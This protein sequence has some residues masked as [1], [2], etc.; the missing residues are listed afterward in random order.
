MFA[1]SVNGLFAPGR[2]RGCFALEPLEPRLLLSAIGAPGP[3]NGWS[4]AAAVSVSASS[5]HAVRPGVRAID[6]SGLDAAGELHD[7]SHEHMWLSG[8]LGASSAA[9]N[10]G[11]VAGSHWIR[12]DFDRGYHLTEAWIWNYN[13]LNWP[14]FGMKDVTIQYSATGGPGPAEWSTA[15][16]GRIPF[17]SGAGVNPDQ[18]DLVVD[19]GGAEARHVVITADASGGERNWSIGRPLVHE[20]VGLSEVRFFHDDDFTG[21]AWREAAFASTLANAAMEAQFHG[22]ILTRLTDVRTGRVLLN[23]APAMMD[24]VLPLFGAVDVDLDRATLNLTSTP[25]ARSYALTFPDGTTWTLDWSLAGA[26]LVLSTRAATPTPVTQFNLA[27]PGADLAGH[28]LVMV[29]QNG[30]GHTFTAPWTGTFGD[31]NRRQMPQTLVQPLVGLFAGDD[32]GWV[33]E[34]RDTALGPSVIRSWGAGQTA[35]VML[36]RLFPVATRDPSLYDVHLRTYVDQWQDAVDPYVTWMVDEVGFEPLEVRQPSWLAEIRSQAYVTIG[37]YAGLG[38][39]ARR[40]DPARTFLGRQAEYRAFPFDVGY[41]DYSV[42]PA[43][44]AWLATARGLGFHVGVH[45]NIA[46]IDRNDTALIEQF[47]PGLR[48]VGTDG[49]GQP[50]W[51]GTGTHV[52]VSAAHAPWRAFLIDAIADVVAAGADVIYLDQ[53]TAPIGRYLVDGVNGI[54][55]VVQLERELLEAYPHVVIQTEQF[56][57]MASRHAGLAL[58]TLSVG[59]P[60]S[61]YVFERFVKVVPEGIWYQPTDTALLDELADWGHFVPGASTEPGWL[62]IAGAFQQYDLA[63][64]SRLPRGPGQGSGFSGPGGVTAFFERTA[65]TRRFAVYEPGVP[66]AA[67]GERHTNI[68]RWSGPGAIADWLIHD[69]GTM[70]G[71]DPQRTYRFDTSVTLDPAR[72]HLTAVPD[73]YLPHFDADRRIVAQETGFDDTNFRLF[74]TGSGQVTMHVP[75]AYDVYLDDVQVAVDRATDTAVVT[76]AAPAGRPAV[77][78]AFARSAQPLDGRWSDHAWTRPQHKIAYVSQ[79]DSLFQPDG[80]FNHIG[81][82]GFII[83]WLPE[84]E[85]VHVLGGWQL[86]DTF[87]ATGGDGVLRVNGTE[88]LRLDPGDAPGPVDT[89]PMPFDVDLTAWSGRFVM[90]EF[91]VDG[92]VHGPEAADWIAPEFVVTAPVPDTFV[93]IGDPRSANGWRTTDAVRV[94]AWSSQKVTRPWLR[95]IDGSGLDGP[96]GSEHDNAFAHMGLTDVLAFGSPARGGTVP[97]SHWVEYDLGAAYL[98]EQMWIWNYNELNW[99]AFGMKDVTIEYSVTGSTNATDWTTAFDGRIPRA[100]ANGA[101]AGRADRVVLFGGARARYVVITTDAGP[102]M[103]HFGDGSVVDVGLSEVRFYARPP[104]QPPTQVGPLSAANVGPHAATVSWGPATDPED[105]ALIYDVQVRADDL[106]EPWSASIATSATTT[107]LAGLRDG[108][109]YRVRVR[110]RDAEGAGA[111]RVAPGLFTTVAVPPRVEAVFVGAS[112][113]SA[114]FLESVDPGARRGYPIPAGDPDQLAPLPWPGLDRV[115]IV[116]S[117]YVQLTPADIVLHGVTT[118]V[119]GVTAFDYDTATFAATW[120]FASPVVADRLAIVLE[121][122]IVDGQHL[123]LDG[124]WTDTV[125][126]VSGNGVAGGAFRFRL[127]VL[128]G[129]LNR[130][131]ATTVLD[132]GPLRDALSAPSPA[133]DLDGDGALTAAD[134]MA[135]RAH[136]GNRLPDGDPP[137]AAAAPISLLAIASQADGR[138]AAVR[139]PSSRHAPW[140]RGPVAASARW[141]ARFMNHPG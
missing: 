1:P 126:L 55:G 52:Y 49:H 82:E 71:L 37:D 57:P 69:G 85:R 66:P 65:T 41:P 33:I 3:A 15:F 84:A 56:N 141:A 128:V 131:G 99:A 28:D 75:D 135:L 39:L 102:H 134:G 12:F 87:V 124:E 51:D 116:F 31:P 108:T 132:V 97:G 119:H 14:W 83:G 93:A 20:E 74:Q 106:S 109:A 104:N 118:G 95:T 63:P 111:W 78:R 77:I 73:D 21:P 25:N 112:T 35:E 100:G 30:T 94:R 47:R 48:Q 6:G 43:A 2:G 67:Y 79:Q 13:E 19:F 27:F 44:A 98:L 101:G 46:G 96:T 86:R 107:A 60:L 127:N 7:N 26:D 110:A 136:L 123:A 32:G 81:G 36:S 76:L 16:D 103:N 11:T 5:A 9:P 70:Y 29:D 105:D 129:D 24:P 23:A 125:S 10:P 92:P 18:V 138:A 22:G 34:G 139:R 91:A 53:S 117:E 8:L 88:V 54:Q 4:T 113:W 114:A 89:G 68:R 137:G 115:T 42:T 50:I 45:V 38:D 121:D 90:F 58:T 80:F 59:H 64:D 72:F 130:D 120:S 17:A 122:H 133:A 140:R 40:V 61:G 62:E